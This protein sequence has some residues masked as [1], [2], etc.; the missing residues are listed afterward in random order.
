MLTNE[1]GREPETQPLTVLLLMLSVR[2]LGHAHTQF[3]ASGFSPFAGERWR[4]A[5]HSLPP[6]A[7][8]SVLCFCVV[9]DRVPARARG[10]HRSP[11][12]LPGAWQ[13]LLGWRCCSQ[14]TRTGPRAAHV[15][16]RCRTG[17]GVPFSE[18]GVFLSPPFTCSFCP[19]H[20]VPIDLPV[21]N[22]A[23]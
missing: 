18:R 11:A 21:R 20:L 13:L 3:H 19:F 2:L 6:Q 7:G 14:G 12:S 8:V 23:E 15:R 1:R 10:G 9:L 22:P 5:Q 17:A 16:G 4:A